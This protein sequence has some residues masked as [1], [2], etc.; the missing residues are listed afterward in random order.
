MEGHKGEHL[1]TWALQQWQHIGSHQ[2]V[3]ALTREGRI[4][5]N[6][7][8]VADFHRLSVGDHVTLHMEP[9]VLS[10]SHTF[11]RRQEVCAEHQGIRLE[12]FCKIFFSDILTSRKAIREAVKQGSVRVDGMQL[13]HTRILQEGSLVEM[14]LPAVEALRALC[15]ANCWPRIVHEDNAIAVVWKEANVKSTGGWQT[16]ENGARLQVKASRDSDAFDERLKSVHRLDKPVAGLMLMAKTYAAHRQ[17]ML[18]LKER[19]QISKIYRAIVEGDPLPKAQKVDLKQL[20]GTSLQGLWSF[21]VDV[22]VEGRESLSY[23]RKI[24]EIDGFSVLELSPITG[25]RH[26]LRLHMASLGCPILGDSEYGHVSHRN[27]R[28]RGM[29]LASVGLR[30]PHPI[31]GEVMVFQEPEPP[32]FQCWRLAQGESR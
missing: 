24:E 31:T 27:H 9:H 20:N 29:L 26:Q 7:C 19:G 6:G 8:R 4:L 25:R 30:F 12:G 28:V 14:S 15:P 1:Y 16:A 11:V 32:H 18:W 10:L 3:K 17:L 23:G 5:V 13:E 22:P 2:S 21:Q